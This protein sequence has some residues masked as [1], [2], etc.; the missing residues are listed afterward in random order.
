MSPSWPD[1]AAVSDLA[2]IAFFF[3]LCVGKYTTVKG[4]NP[5]RTVQFCMLDVI[6]YKSG[7]AILSSSPLA[8]LLETDWATLT[9]NNQKNGLQGQTIMAWATRTLICPV[10][11]LARRVMAVYAATADV[12]APICIVGHC[13]GLHIIPEPAIWR[14]VNRAVRHL[15]F[16]SVGIGP[17]DVGVH[18]LQA[19]GAMSL[20]LNGANMLTIIHYGRWMSLS[21]MSCIHN[22]IAYLTTPVSRLMAQPIPFLNIVQCR[23]T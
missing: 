12:T 3:L 2:I 17:R 15:G 1:V 19:V 16:A 4:R 7:V 13:R 8:I 20:K 14:A 22:Q 21:F 9:I 5:T 23:F 11:A 18:L 6:F 10:R